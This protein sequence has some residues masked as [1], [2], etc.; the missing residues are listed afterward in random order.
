MIYLKIYILFENFAEELQRFQFHLFR[1]YGRTNLGV[2]FLFR[3]L[4]AD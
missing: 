2:E 4:T 3:P 1:K